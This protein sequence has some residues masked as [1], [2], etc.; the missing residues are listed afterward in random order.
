MRALRCAGRRAWAAGLLLA[1]ACAVWR[2][3]P[4]ANVAMGGL[5]S[6]QTGVPWNARREGAREYWT[7]DGSELQQLIF[8][9]GIAAGEAL[10]AEAWFTG[11]EQ[12]ERRH[13]FEP[14][15][16]YLAL[17]E[18]VSNTWSTGSWQAVETRGL[19]PA[20]FGPFEGFRFELSM[21]SPAGLEYQGIAAGTVQNERLYLV[22][23][24]GAR[25]HS[26]EAHL[27]DVEELLGSIRPL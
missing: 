10:F 25:L 17:E 12:R 11:A 7:I 21:R 2:A 18:L 14:S 20:P 4:E 8:F 16:D 23:Y 9:N 19:R 27:P 15:M 24:E 6:V 3:V 22:V 13:R 5:Y 1:A 26:Y